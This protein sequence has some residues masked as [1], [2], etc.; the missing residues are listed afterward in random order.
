MRFRTVW[1]PHEIRIQG[2]E[3][4]PRLE[5]KDQYSTIEEAKADIT[6][7]FTLQ[8]LMSEADQGRLQT[9]LQHG[10]AAERQLY[11]TFLASAFR[12]LRFGLQDAHARGMAIQFNY[13]R[14]KGGFVENPDGTFSVDFVKIKDAVRALDHDFL[15]IEATGDYA[16]AK[17][18]ISELAVIRP[19]VQ[20]ALDRLKSIPT[21]IEP[22]FDT[23]RR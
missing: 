7:L 8:F 9:P 4:N 5:L 19:E 14:D 12:T 17:R 6:G 1:G 23:V 18:M 13:L 16:A 10:S 2:R 20:R 15:T 22:V 21:D 11:T 3:T